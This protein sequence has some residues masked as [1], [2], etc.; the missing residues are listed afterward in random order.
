MTAGR[1][2]SICKVIRSFAPVF[3]TL[4]SPV[5][6]ILVLNTGRHTEDPRHAP[7][8]KQLLMV[9][10]DVTQMH[11]LEGA[12]R[13]L[14]ANVSHELRTPL[15]VLLQGYLEMMQEQALEGDAKRFNAHDARANVC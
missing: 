14:F 13:Q 12:R 9:A 11:Q 1:I 6:F 3:K 7:A 4:I 15:T 2:F 5:R 10:R 8:D